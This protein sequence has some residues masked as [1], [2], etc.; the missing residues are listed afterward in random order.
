MRNAAIP[1]KP[2]IS[3]TY[4]CFCLGRVLNHQ[5][6]SQQIILPRPITRPLDR[7][8]SQRSSLRLHS[9]TNLPLPTQDQ[10]PYRPFQP[11]LLVSQQD[12]R[13][14]PTIHRLHRPPQPFLPCPQTHRSFHGRHSAHP[15]LA[16]SVILHVHTNP[17]S[18]R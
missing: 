18:N 7:C 8:S 6:T 15:P 11:L 9:Y 4:P 10:I 1:I 14:P 17:K 12:I 16:T 2:S 5:W 13:P 3:V